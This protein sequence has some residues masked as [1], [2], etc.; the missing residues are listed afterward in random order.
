MDFIEKFFGW[1]NFGD[2][3][4]T[5]IS[6]LIKNVG[7]WYKSVYPSLITLQ[8][9][10]YIPNRYIGE[11]GR[12]ISDKLSIDGYL[13]AVDIEWK[14]IPFHLIKSTIGINFKFHSNLDYEDSKILSF[15]SFYKQLL[16]HWRKKLSSSFNIS[17][18]ILSQRIWY[19]KSIKIQ[20]KPTYVEEIA[21]QNVIF[22][23]DLFN[24]KNELKTWGEMKI[25]YELS[26]LI[27]NDDKLSI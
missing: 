21:K 25:T 3:P 13:V 10:A 17:S 22:L 8:W 20:S 11:A 26:N 4:K 27:S 2:V 24:A 15:P 12:L 14:L 7:G 9:T 19:H 6:E 16:L 18:Y 1:K 23:Y 5:G